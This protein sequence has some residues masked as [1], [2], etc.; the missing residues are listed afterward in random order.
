MAGRGSAVRRGRAE[1]VATAG[2][3]CGC[4][5][6]VCGAVPGVGGR[7]LLFVWLD[8]TRICALVAQ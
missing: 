7:G 5:N 8:A 1:G 6:V 4:L 2:A 3:C